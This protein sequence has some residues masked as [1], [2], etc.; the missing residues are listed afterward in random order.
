[1]LG[2]ILYSIE[3][4]EATRKYSFVSDTFWFESLESVDHTQLKDKLLMKNSRMKL[5]VLVQKTN[6][7]HGMNNFTTTVFY[8]TVSI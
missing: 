3:L 7:G 4:Y 2:H 1:M 6:S 5:L 8:R